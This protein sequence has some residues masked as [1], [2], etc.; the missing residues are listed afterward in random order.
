M[1]GRL[2]LFK[3]TYGTIDQATPAPRTPLYI[4]M[5]QIGEYFTRQM[6]RR[7]RQSQKIRLERSEQGA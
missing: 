5:R 6:A 2:R 3:S 7:L 1:M 4:F